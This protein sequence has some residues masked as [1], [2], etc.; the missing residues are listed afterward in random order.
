[1]HFEQQ[2]AYT[3]R[4]C[5]IKSQVSKASLR[6]KHFFLPFF[7]LKAACPKNSVLI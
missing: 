6:W 2:I 7:L 5:I 4:A 1:M 3:T